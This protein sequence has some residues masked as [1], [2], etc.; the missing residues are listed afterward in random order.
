MRLLDCGGILALQNTNVK[1]SELNTMHERFLVA[2][3]DF[4]R[5]GKLIY[6]FRNTGYIIC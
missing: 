6:G 1:C 5:G 3:I 4:T 2:K